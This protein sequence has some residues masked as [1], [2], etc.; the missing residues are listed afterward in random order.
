MDML[1]EIQ[2]VIEISKKSVGCLQ[3]EEDPIKN[4]IY[5]TII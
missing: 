2:R 1:E 5:D 4:L 3:K